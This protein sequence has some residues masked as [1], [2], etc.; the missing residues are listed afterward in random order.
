MSSLSSS[1]PIDAPSWSLL[2]TEPLRAAIEYVG[3]RL[4]TRDFLPTGDGHPVV[5]FPGLAAER[6]SIAPLKKFCEELGY[7]AYDWGRGFN[8]GPHG[9]LDGWINDLAQHVRELTLM[10]DQR[11]S[12]IG[13]SL[14]G[15]YA[16][17]VAKKLPEKVRQVITL[18]T[19]IGNALEQNHV[20]WLYRLLNGQRPPLD[21]SLLLRM[22]TA[23]QVP[24][25]AIFSRSDG[26]VAWQACLQEGTRNDTENIEVRSSHCG[27]GWNS[28]VLEIIAGRLGQRENE[29]KRDLRSV[30]A[31][32]AWKA[33][34]GVVQQGERH[35]QTPG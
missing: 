15:I 8:T 33:S 12:L 26:I 35:W 24:T 31:V 1:S 28:E 22:R 34:D 27:L 10:H 6:H 9:N 2:A 11:I 13:W 21:D 5:I 4:M 16:R 19:P 29:W 20:S 23:P 18:G 32:Q 30:T 25:T 7:A 17:E 3:M 14:G